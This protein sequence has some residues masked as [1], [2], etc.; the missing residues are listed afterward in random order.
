MKNL[1][2]VLFFIVLFSG[3][4]EIIDVPQVR[5][6]QNKSILLN[7]DTFTHKARVPKLIVLKDKKHILTCS[8]DKTVLLTNIETKKIVKRYLG[9]IG[10][11]F[12]SVYSIAL[13]PDEKYLLT[14]GWFAEGGGINNDKV[15]W[16][17]VY[18]FKTGKIVKVL[19]GHKNIISDL[20][21]SQDNK[22]L[23][24][25]SADATIQVRTLPDFNIVGTY[26]YSRYVNQFKIFDNKIFSVDNDWKVKIRNL[27]TGKLIRYVSLLGEI[28]LTKKRRTP[29]FLYIAVNSNNIVVSTGTKDDAIIVLDYELNIL[30]RIPVKD[31]AAGLKYSKDGKY[32]ITGSG[33]HS[34]LKKERCIK[35]YDASQ[36]YTLISKFD[37]FDSFHNYVGAVG[38]LDSKKAI[39]VGGNNHNI[40][41][42]DILNTKEIKSLKSRGSAKPAVALIGNKIIWRNEIITRKSVLDKYFDIDQMKL[43][44]EKINIKDVKR[45]PLSY[46]DYELKQSINSHGLILFQ[47]NKSLF[48]L[49]S[50][51]GHKFYGFYKGYIVS[52]NYKGNINI[53]TLKGNLIYSLQ[54]H[55]GVVASVHF[56]DDF[57][58]SSGSDMT[59]KLWK[60]PKKSNI[61]NPIVISPL[62]S[63]YIMNDDKWIMWTPE[64]YFTEFGDSAKY[65]YFHLN[66]G[67]TKEAKEV[68]IDKLYDYF[69]RP[70][71]VKLKLQGV[72]ITKYTKGL[73][74]V[75]VLKTPPPSVVIYS[76]RS[77]DINKR[78]RTV[79]LKFKVIENDNGGVGVI[80]IYQEGKLVKTL[81]DAKINRRIANVDKKL[82]EERLNK[83]AKQRQA[84]YLALQKSVSKS[85]K[86]T[87][88]S[89]D[90]LV[91]DVEIIAAQN[92]A[93]EY[94][95]TLPLKAGKN[96]ISIEAFNKTNTVASI[97]ENIV[98]HAK[99]KKRRPKIYAIV[100]GV[101]K[102][103]QDNVSQLKYSENDAKT[104]AKEIKRA[105]RLKTEVTLLRGKNVTK[106][107]IYKAIA[108]IEKKAHLE[109]KIVFYI[110]THGKASRGQL[111]LVPHNNKKLKNWIKFEELFAKIQAI[112]ALEQI[113]II[114]ACESGSASDIMASVYD[115]KASVLAKQ[116]G[117]HLLMATTKGTFAFESAD[118]NIHHGV[119]TNNILKALSS[120]STD[121][122][123]DRTISIIELSKALQEPQYSV[124]Q[125]FPV[126]RNVGEDT[127]IKRIRR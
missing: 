52:A 26:S 3:C 104:M 18:D 64:G 12:G 16:I 40:R 38:F 125:Q 127:E 30:Q 102:F 48:T 96:T 44:K 119:F 124:K 1:I 110:S 75:D 51:D 19:T 59:I 34:T 36:N 41:I 31:G 47:N 89:D 113:F 20:E 55:K 108:K 84:E 24:S 83:L 99:I 50:S 111:Y 100:V 123:R 45:L 7:I 33:G 22:Y 86:G 58:I 28:D 42:W 8:D 112:P 46:K 87:L 118:K 97:R 17:R 21:F 88:V 69:F 54:G 49:N 9:E 68:S 63:L 61:L 107:K 65:I 92:K 60:L 98:V 116:S 14:G 73:T 6:T 95:V 57:L 105:T 103:E 71:L 4:A 90:D 121:K 43:V 91:G 39:A 15:G 10:D 126:I 80:R 94:T 93:G 25:S 53:F 70:D 66:Q 82:E 76:V 5:H 78:K 85:V 67:F 35:I 106:E 122:N 27:S 72:D 101:N 37:K 117:V 29:R 2:L 13:S 11:G 120:K 77:K 115:A 79:R 32:L 56:N 81:G 62:A 74:Y 114:D 23:I 109:D